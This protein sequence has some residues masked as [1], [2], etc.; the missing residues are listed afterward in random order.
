VC[1]NAITHVKEKTPGWEKYPDQWDV[2]G[3]DFDPRHCYGKAAV[4]ALAKTIH[5]AIHA[6]A[7][8]LWFPA[9]DPY[10]Q[11]LVDACFGE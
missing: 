10:V 3:V 6:C 5:E 7:N 8:Q 4:K 1:A 9:V 11:P 2:T